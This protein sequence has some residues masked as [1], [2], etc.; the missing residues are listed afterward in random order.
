MRHRIVSVAGGLVAL[1]VA[2]RV[3]PRARRAA[4]PPRAPYGALVRNRLSLIPL[5]LAVLVALGGAPAV[6]NADFK[7]VFAD[8]NDGTI[9]GKFTAKELQQALQNADAF[10]GDYSECADAIFRAQASQGG[11]G[12]GAGGSTGSGGSSDGAGSTGS[13]STGSSGGATTSGGGAA[14]TTPGGG[15]TG[16][17]GG[18]AATADR[19]NDAR[20]ADA[21]EKAAAL[22]AATASADKKAG[23]TASE[24]KNIGV[25][26]AALEY[27]GTD[28]TLP[29]PLLLTL[30]ACALA[31]C[32]AGAATGAQALRRRRGR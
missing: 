1:G 13:G 14:T 12:S 2:D 26:A 10:A 19:Q 22:A 8:C 32:I 9:D 31:A 27:G 18:A 24:L 21:A 20:D 6:A 30:V 11:S 29:G 25:P 23:D 15:G 16:T 17:S 4:G 5:L 3:R 28:T 7:D